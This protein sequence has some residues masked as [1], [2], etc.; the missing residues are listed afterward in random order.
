MTRSA[1]KRGVIDDAA[2]R[3]AATVAQALG[4]FPPAGRPSTATGHGR[5]TPTSCSSSDFSGKSRRHRSSAEADATNDANN[6]PTHQPSRTHPCSGSATRV[7]RHQRRD[8]P[9]TIGTKTR[10]TPSARQ[11]GRARHRR[12]PARTPEDVAS[13]PTHSTSHSTRNSPTVGPAGSVGARVPSS[14]S[15]KN[16]RSADSAS[17]F[18]RY[19]PARPA[20]ARAEHRRSLVP[21]RRTTNSRRVSSLPSEGPPRCG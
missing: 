13:T 15:I 14:S 17:H 2:L 4:Y 12:P 21:T 18:V 9:T 8:A 3:A 5:G 1:F 11:P 10:P 7:T 19:P 20:G 6:R 16:R